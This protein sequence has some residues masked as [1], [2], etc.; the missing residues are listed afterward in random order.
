MNR[1]SW[2]PVPGFALK[3]GLGELA[4]VMTTGQHVTPQVAQQE[5]FTFSYPT[6]EQALHSIFEE[7]R[8]QL[9]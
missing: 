1:P 7:P 8:V 2:L 4:T 9:R 6:L 3:L 5:G